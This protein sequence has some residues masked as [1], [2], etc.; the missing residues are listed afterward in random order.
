MLKKTLRIAFL[1]TLV[2]AGATAAIAI[3]LEAPLFSDLRRTIVADYLSEQIGQPLVI[4]ND[5][6]A[7][8]GLSQTR[9]LVSGVE[10]PSEDIDGVNLAEMSLLEL[11]F[12]LLAALS[13][14][15]RID[16]VKID[17]IRV[18]LTTLPDGATT[19]SAEPPVETDATSTTGGL[20]G[21]NDIIFFLSDKNV[22]LESINLAVNNQVTGFEFDYELSAMKLVQRD[23]GRKVSL[24]AEGLVNGLPFKVDGLY[25][26]GKTS[27]TTLD[28]GKLNVVFLAQALSKPDGGGIAGTLDITTNEIGDLFEVLKLDRSAEGTGK[29]SLVLDSQNDRLSVDA[30]DARIE[31]QNGMAFGLIGA[32][33]DLISLDGVDLEF[34][35]DFYPQGDIPRP[36]N[37]LKDLKL[38]NVRT[39]LVGEGGKISIEEMIVETNMFETDFQNIGPFTVGNV[40]RTENGALALQDVTMQLGPVE[41]PYIMASGSISDLLNARGIELSVKLNGPASLVFP[42]LSRDQS[43]DFGNV[44]G[45]FQLSDK[46]GQLALSHLDVFSENT[47]LWNLQATAHASS[48]ETVK[49]A[50]FDIAFSIPDGSNFLESLQADVVDVGPV[51]VSTSV[52]GVDGGVEIALMGQVNKSALSAKITSTV[53]DNQRVKMRGQIFSES[54]KLADVDKAAEIAVS[55]E[56]WRDGVPQTTAGRN[57]TREVWPLVLEEQAPEG[58]AKK[59]EP[60]LDG[61]IVQPLVINEIDFIQAGAGDRVVLPLVI[62]PVPLAELQLADLLDPVKIGREMDVEIGL[63]IEKITGAAGVSRISSELVSKGGKADFGPIELRYGDGYVSLGAGINFIDTPQLVRFYGSTAGWDFGKIL[64]EIGLGI[65]ARGKIKARFDLT[66]QNTSAARFANTA[67]GSVNMTMNNAQIGTSLLELAGLG[68]FP[69]LFSKE[70]NKGYTDIVCVVAPLRIRGGKASSSSMVLE[71]KR[72]QLVAAGTIDWAN[73]RISLRGEPRPVGRALR[74]S[75]W[76]FEVSGRLSNP[77][78]KI[79]R[80]PKDNPIDRKAGEGTPSSARQTCVPDIKQTQ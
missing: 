34:T 60:S 54:I 63:N 27:I 77:D 35:G 2:L 55:L 6:N 61:R 74:K 52:K 18:D 17:G 30:L 36:A 25:P 38:A 78:F 21:T 32:A 31:L 28:F 1:S 50:D 66:G 43:A 69:W 42:E 58:A 44:A 23:S 33:S 45:A 75:P 49:G 57:D 37:T 72:V 80:R 19:W 11:D 22:E 3:V 40:R 24:D 41:D 76:P 51:A 14:K 9:L 56:K 68:L 62:E 39:R 20:K 73:D 70:L 12:Q 15:L 13:G 46:T 8:L 4:K 48:F 47:E 10:I 26:S 5:V 71:T 29:V 64:E 7:K 16:N 65:Q 53:D 67:N 79:V 59:N